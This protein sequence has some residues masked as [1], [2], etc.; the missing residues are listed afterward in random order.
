MGIVAGDDQAVQGH[1]GQGGVNAAA[2]RET[3]RR[4]LD[5]GVDCDTLHVQV[6]AVDVQ[7][8]A[9]VGHRITG[10]FPAGHV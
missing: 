4:G 2:V 9:V 10:N 8:G 5:V 6:A 7:A 1:G 3:S